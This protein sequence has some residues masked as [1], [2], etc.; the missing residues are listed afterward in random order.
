MLRSVSEVNKGKKRQIREEDKVK[1]VGLVAGECRS[2]Q[3]C[4]YKK[5]LVIPRSLVELR[6][7]VASY[8]SSVATAKAWR[9]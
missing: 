2:P 6:L 9:Q 3:R 4:A 5:R 1:S 7:Q 8:E